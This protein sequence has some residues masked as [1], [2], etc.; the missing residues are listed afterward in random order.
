MAKFEEPFED[1]KQIF[2]TVIDGT[3]LERNVNIKILTN[4]K[5]KEIGTVT[6]TNELVQFLSSENIII[7]VN[8]E[9]FEMLDELQKTL[10]ADSLVTAIEYD[11]EK[12]KI[13]LRK[14]DVVGHSGV[15]TKYGERVF[16]NTLET[17]KLTF[18]QLKGKKEEEGVEA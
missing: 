9:V 10:V 8:E 14:P 4:N 17:I 7:Q 12:G 18:A 3:D 16:L 1:T 6:K 11:A 13:S 15:I 2:Q 5:L